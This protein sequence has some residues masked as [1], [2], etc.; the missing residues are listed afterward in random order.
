MKR[1][2]N[3]ERGSIELIVL[4]LLATLIVLLAIPALIRVGGSTEQALDNAADALEQGQNYV[5]PGP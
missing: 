5:P 4:G 2:T 1:K 3:K